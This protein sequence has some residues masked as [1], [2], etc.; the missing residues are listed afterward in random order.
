MMVLKALYI[1]PVAGEVFLC[2]CR[3]WIAGRNHIIQGDACCL[4]NIE[5]DRGTGNK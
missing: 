5:I 4:N 1:S 3:N 2:M